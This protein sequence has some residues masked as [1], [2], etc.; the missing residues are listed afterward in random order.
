TTAL[1]DP[2]TATDARYS[3]VQDVIAHEATHNWRGNR[4]TIKNWFQVCLKEG[5]TTFTEQEFSAEMTAST[6]AVKRIEDVI[7]MRSSQFPEDASAI[8]H[9]I[10]PSSVGSIENFYTPTV[11][12]KG[13]EVIRMIKTLIGPNNFRKGMDLYFTRYDGQAITT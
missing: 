11:Y 13:A 2:Q 5:L 6:P 3:V 8:A 4:V 7:A 10:R 12:E 9:P 1:A